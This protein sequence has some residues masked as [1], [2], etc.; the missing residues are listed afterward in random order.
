MRWNFA[1]I[2]LLIAS[3]AQ[4]QATTSRRFFQ[5]FEEPGQ[6]FAFVDL[7]SQLQTGQSYV[8]NFPLK[9]DQGWVPERVAVS[10]GGSN[11]NVVSDGIIATYHQSA[12]PL[13][14][15]QRSGG[16]VIARWSI[17]NAVDKRRKLETFLKYELHLNQ[18]TGAAKLFVR[19]D[20]FSN[21]FR[22]T[23]K[24]SLR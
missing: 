18:D 9:R 3:Q 2:F 19:P 4:A 22:G 1:L 23:G 7:P 6:R 8:C 10:F 14:Y 11:G 13:T 12:R 16:R 21:K 20:S 24:C 17:R 5:E 15:R